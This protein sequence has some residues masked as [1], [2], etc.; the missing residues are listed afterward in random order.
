MSTLPA[1][2]VLLVSLLYLGLLFVIAL[3]VDRRAAEG[4]SLIASPTIYALSLAVYC[5][6]WTFFGSVGLAA[7]QGVAFLPTYLGPTLMALLWPTLLVKCLR[8]A[9]RDRITTIAD[10][11]ASRYGKRRGLAALVAVICVIGVLPYIALQL[12]A[13]AASFTLLTGGS[14]AV[15]GGLFADTALVIALV[16]AVFTMIFGTRHL[17]AMERH[18]G[19]VA[20]IAFESVVKLIAFLAVGLFVVYALFDGARDLFARAAADPQLARLWHFEASAGGWFD[21]TLLIGL[22]MAAIMLLPRQFQVAVVENVDEAHVRRASWLF[23]AY[24]LAINLFVLPL[25]CAGVLLLGDTVAADTYVLALPLQ[26]GQSWLALFVFIGGTSAATGMIIV[27][28]TALATMISND[29]VLPGL[30]HRARAADIGRWLLLIRRAAIV[31]VV[32]LGYLYFRIAGEAR[33]LVSIGLISFAAVA[34]LT[35]AFIGALYWR[36]GTRA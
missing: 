32:L 33:S 31:L 29:L 25:A 16:M 17:D 10:F 20:A 2:G 13:V 8:I 18:E 35:P 28:T 36:N 21:W 23:P 4:R 3:V 19:L 22:S 11:I 5:T 30:L 7:T 15:Q 1:A 26:A 24:L 6:S 14:V 34:Q 9:K 27:E 12:K